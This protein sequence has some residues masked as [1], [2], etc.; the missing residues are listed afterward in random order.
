MASSSG[1][2]S[3][4]INS[5]RAIADEVIDVDS[6]ESRNKKQKTGDKAEGLC[7]PPLGAIRVERVK[8]APV[9]IIGVVAARV[10]EEPVYENSKCGEPSEGDEK[11]DWVVERLP[12]ERDHPD[13]GQQDTESGD[14]LDIDL[15]GK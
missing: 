5:N 6:Q 7:G 1:A 9:V 4:I 14:D 13:Q 3:G 10:I 12:S 8:N 11:V 15:S 2:L